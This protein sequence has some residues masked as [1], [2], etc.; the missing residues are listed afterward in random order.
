MD[1][2]IPYHI[3]CKKSPICLGRS[4]EKEGKKGTSSVDGPPLELTSKQAGMENCTEAA[5][6]GKGSPL[7]EALSSFLEKPKTLQVV[8]A[9]EK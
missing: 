1:F 5:A 2:S 7:A 8:S 9:E 6:N 3:S 4:M